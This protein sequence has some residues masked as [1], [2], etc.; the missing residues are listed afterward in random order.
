MDDL[1]DEVRRQNIRC[2]SHIYFGGAAWGCAYYV[3]CCQGLEACFGNKNLSRTVFLGDSAGALMALGMSLGRG[4]N[5]LDSI[6]KKLAENAS[7]K[8]VIGKMSIYHQEAIDSLLSTEDESAS[9]S[10]KRLNTTRAFGVGTTQFFDQHKFHHRFESLQVLYDTLH[11]SFHIPFYCA[12]DGEPCVEWISG[13]PV[14]DGAY[15]LRG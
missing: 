11:G 2:P 9:T 12:Y 14:V 5:K 3:G 7:E 10:L 4:S 1:A 8:G 15:S 13:K 6:Y